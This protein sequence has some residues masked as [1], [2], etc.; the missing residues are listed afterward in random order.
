MSPRFIEMEANTLDEAKALAYAQIPDGFFVF[1]ES[2]ISDGMPKTIRAIRESLE[3]AVRESESK[4]PSQANVLQHVKEV[5]TERRTLDFYDY[6]EKGA[7]E[8]AQRKNS[9]LSEK[10]ESFQLHE[11]RSKDF[12]GLGREK[13]IYRATYA[14]QQH[15]VEIVY[16]EKAKI[17]L[18]LDK[19]W[20][21][22]LKLDFLRTFL[23]D[24][25]S[26]FSTS[27]YSH[28]DAKYKEWCRHHDK[29]SGNKSGG[30]SFFGVLDDLIYDDAH[31]D[32]PWNNF[33]LTDKG[34]AFILSGG[35]S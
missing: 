21:D 13:N 33:Q 15:V 18:D 28:F 12:L 35:Q 17:R 11:Q 3:E 25:D 20:T 14:I 24:P 22:E 30:Y 5:L 31:G 7:R 4:I 8:Q 29:K 16:Q 19:E 1:S 23:P 10:I 2:I 34:R 6:S 26:T 32:D 9:L 27:S